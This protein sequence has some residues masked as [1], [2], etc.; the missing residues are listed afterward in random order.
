MKNMIFSLFFLFATSFD[1]LAQTSFF[2]GKTARI[3][4][5]FSPG[6]S[7][8][9]WARLIARH[10]GKHIPGNP[11]FIVQNMTGGGSMVAANYVYKVAKPDGLTIAVVTPGLFIEQL[12]G[13]KEVQFDWT[14]FSLVGSPERTERIFYIRADTPYKTLEDLR[15]ATEPP[16]CGTT[17]VGTASYYWPRLLG[18]MFGFKLNLVP[19]YQG[20]S[21]VNLAIEKGEMHCWGG[22]LQA[23]FG[24]EPGRTWAKTGFVRVLTHGGKKR[25]QQLSDTP[26]V[27]ELMDKHKIGDATGQLVKVLLSPDDLGRP[28]F[29]PPGVP[30]DRVKMLRE[31]FAKIMHDPDVVAEAQKKGLDPNLVSGDELE[32]LIKELIALPPEVIQRMKKLME[33]PA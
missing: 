18:D 33:K 14:R 30:A 24:S 5:G 28:F 26:T 22:T 32:G 20:S 25:H 3:L 2:E 23:Y 15:M 16:K 21:D 10:M 8:D 19:G 9:L 27:W 17:G 13:R 12:A 4:V 1:L 6:G 11:S 29:G 31:A 7:Y